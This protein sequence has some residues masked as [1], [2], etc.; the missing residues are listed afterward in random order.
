M[1]LRL[2][3]V[4]PPCYAKSMKKGK[5]ELRRL[6]ELRRSSA[7]TPIRNKTKYD[8]QSMKRDLNHIRKDLTY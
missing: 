1:I 6:M 8:R 4:T 7:S 2:P 3:I 5:E